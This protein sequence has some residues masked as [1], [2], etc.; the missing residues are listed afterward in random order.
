MNLGL[1]M[2]AYQYLQT[3]LH[4]IK[5]STGRRK[6]ISRNN[7]LGRSPMPSMLGSSLFFSDP[8]LQSITR[9]AKPAYEHN[10]KNKTKQPMFMLKNMI[11]SNNT[12]ATIT[13]C[14]NKVEGLRTKL[15]K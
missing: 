3:H 5:D 9:E 1:L 2:T 15:T 4:R 6:R 12:P 7:S 10:Y 14:H 13:I 11:S 8:Y